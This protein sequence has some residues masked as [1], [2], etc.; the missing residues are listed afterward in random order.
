LDQEKVKALIYPPV[1]SKPAFE[2]ATSI[3]ET[4]LPVRLLKRITIRNQP[5]SG[6][7]PQRNQDCTETR[8]CDDPGM[9]CSKRGDKYQCG[10]TAEYCEYEPL[11]M[12]KDSENPFYS[13]LKRAPDDSRQTY[14]C[15]MGF[16]ATTCGGC[17]DSD[18]CAKMDGDLL[19]GD[20]MCVDG[21]GK[22]AN[23][24]TL[25]S[26]SNGFK[27][28][29]GY[30]C[31]PRNTVGPDGVSLWIKNGGD[32]DGKSGNIVSQPKNHDGIRKI[33][34]QTGLL[35]EMTDR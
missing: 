28:G 3:L 25:N 29:K 20:C 32:F 5:V 14:E 21:T 33:E 15:N 8:H 4:L 1:V 23:C 27:N 7:L 6:V 19:V 9:C 26:S 10:S 35:P 30:Y 31:V 12:Q 11:T 34:Y 22:Q 18:W 2:Y 17:Y 24:K 13:Y 16:M